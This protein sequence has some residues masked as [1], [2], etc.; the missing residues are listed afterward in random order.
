MPSEHD[1]GSGGVLTSLFFL[2]LATLAAVLCDFSLR[3]VTS[4]F[5]KGAEDEG[6]LLVR[7]SKLTGLPTD[8]L[9]KSACDILLRRYLIEM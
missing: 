5:R 3:C 7:L 1:S 4:R 6:R 2:A 9:L 8:I